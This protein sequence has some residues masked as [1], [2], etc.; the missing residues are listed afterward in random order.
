MNYVSSKFIKYDL[1]EICS[2]YV[3]PSDP[4]HSVPPLPQYV[5]GSAVHLLLGIKNTHIKTRSGLKPSKWISSDQSV[6]KD[7]WRS[8]IIFSGPHIIIIAGKLSTKKIH[9]VLP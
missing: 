3:S 7:I 1:S 9:K 8:E 6:F 4:N 5:G 2:E